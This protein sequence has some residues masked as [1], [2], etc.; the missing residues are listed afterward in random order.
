M[1]LRAL[2]FELLSPFHFT[3]VADAGFGSSTQTGGKNAAVRDLGAPHGARTV[4]PDR[5][6]ERRGFDSRPHS[7]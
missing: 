3:Y 7:P 1:L 6:P 4:A 5:Y 2:P